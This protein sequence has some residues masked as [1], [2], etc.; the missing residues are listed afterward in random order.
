LF[1]IIQMISIGEAAKQLIQKIPFLEEAIVED[2][3]NISSLARKLQPQIEEVLQKEVQVGAI[4][5]GI[6]R[7]KPEFMH[8]FSSGLKKFVGDLGDLIVRSG[9]MHFTFENSGSLGSR[10]QDLIKHIGENQAYYS[11]ARGIFETSIVVSNSLTELVINIFSGEKLIFQKQDLS[12]ITLRL[13]KKR[14]D[15]VGFYYYILKNLSL[16]KINI[17]ELISTTNEFTIIVKDKDIDRAFSIL[18][19]LKNPVKFEQAN[20]F[21]P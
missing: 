14:D 18:M 12:S 13:P 17:E 9:L 5:I 7:I 3:V 6:Q 15:T 16:K 8:K 4:I 2:L 20:F 11:V 19:N 1:K 10:Q 21:G